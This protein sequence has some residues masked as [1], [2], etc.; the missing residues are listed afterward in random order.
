LTKFFLRIRSNLTKK[1]LAF[2]PYFTKRSYDYRA[3]NDPK[4]TFEIWSEQNKIRPKINQD[5]VANNDSFSVKK[6]GQ[7][8]SLRAGKLSSY[9]FLYGKSKKIGPDMIS[10][11]PDSSS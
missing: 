5:R 6:F 2:F 3:K 4:G 11:P 10:R 8:W 9:L 7:I 1:I